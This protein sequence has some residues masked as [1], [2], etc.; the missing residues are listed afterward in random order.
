MLALRHPIPRHPAP[1]GLSLMCA[2][3]QE[4]RRGSRPG[5]SRPSASPAEPL[6]W[7]SAKILVAHCLPSRVLGSFFL[8]TKDAVLQQLRVVLGRQGRGEK[9]RARPSFKVPICCGSVPHTNRLDQSRSS[10]LSP[11]SQ[12]SKNGL[13]I[14]RG[15][16]CS[17][18]YAPAPNSFFCVHC[19]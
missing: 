1:Y 3:A 5:F 16:P 10:L 12:K 2:R 4:P 15:R 13:K 7:L 6:K 17:Q 9:Q 18:A 14:V 11:G 8:D 19:S